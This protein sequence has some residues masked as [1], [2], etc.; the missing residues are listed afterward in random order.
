MFLAPTSVTTK[1][2]R[3]TTLPPAV[4]HRLQAPDA[5]VIDGK[6]FRRVQRLPGT[7]AA[8]NKLP[9]KIKLILGRNHKTFYGCNN[10]FIVIS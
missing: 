2:T 9:E 8:K 6:M 10:F 7:L 4:G 3:F 1:K 5:F